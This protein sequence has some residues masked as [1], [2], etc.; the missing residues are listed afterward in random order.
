MLDDLV[1]IRG[2]QNC[3]MPW[4]FRQLRFG[5]VPWEREQHVHQLEHGTRFLKILVAHDGDSTLTFLN[6]AT[7]LIL[8]F[9]G[10]RRGLLP[11]R[12]EYMPLRVYCASIHKLSNGGQ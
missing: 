5:A 12:P 4:L 10:Y 7:G 3:G 8:E 2:V 6:Q 1:L 9:H 11:E